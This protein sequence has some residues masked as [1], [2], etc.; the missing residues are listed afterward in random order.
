MEGMERFQKELKK[1]LGFL[2]RS[3]Q[4]YDEGHID[5]AIR[6]ATI[7]RT[8]INDTGRSISLLKHLNGTGIRLWSTT[9]SAPAGATVYFGMGQY[10]FL[11][12]VSS[13]G[14]SFDDTLAKKTKYK[15]TLTTGAKDAESNALE[16]QLG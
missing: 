8:L 13:Y 1:Q 9:H 16:Q 3:C 10:R 7:L 4:M 15:A 5:E 2:E 14:P 12:E 11:N 6:I